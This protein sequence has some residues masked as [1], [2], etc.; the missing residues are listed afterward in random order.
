MEIKLNGAMDGIDAAEHIRSRLDIPVASIRGTAETEVLERAKRTEP[1]SYLG[2][3]V[4]LLQL[5]STIETALYK[6]AADKRLREREKQLQRLV[7]ELKAYQKELNARNRDLHETH[8]KLEEARGRLADPY[9]FA[10]VGYL[11]TSDEGII[12]ESNLTLTRLA[13]L[14]QK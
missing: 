4:T 10:P 11:T 7:E 8:C 6:H 12:V 13:Q 14:S 3:P 9:D 2:K 5:R 1:Y